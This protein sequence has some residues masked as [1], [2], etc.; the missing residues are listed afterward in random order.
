MT[1]LKLKKFK[2]LLVRTTSHYA[3]F[4]TCGS[5]YPRTGPIGKNPPETNLEPPKILISSRTGPGTGRSFQ[6]VLKHSD[7]QIVLIFFEE[8]TSQKEVNATNIKE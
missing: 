4:C 6:S 2:S 8:N 7:M 5:R 1:T 3:V